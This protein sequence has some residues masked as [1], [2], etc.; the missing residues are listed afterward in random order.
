MTEASS[1]ARHVLLM[2]VRVLKLL[3]YGIP[4]YGAS[5]PGLQQ[6]NLIYLLLEFLLKKVTNKVR[7]GYIDTIGP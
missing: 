6:H 7:I 1:R 2:L 4:Y 5:E 3:L